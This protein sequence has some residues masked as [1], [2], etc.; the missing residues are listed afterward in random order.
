M[1][2]PILINSYSRSGSVFFAELINSIHTP[3]YVSASVLH[4]PEIIGISEAITVT[5]IR[6]PKECITSN[7]FLGLPFN[8]FLEDFKKLD[9]TI[10]YECNHYLKFLKMSKL[11][12][13][14]LVDFK[15]LI[16]NPKNEIVKFLEKNNINKDVVI[17][18]DNILKGIE[19]KKFPDD[20]HDLY[21]GHFP[22]GAH[23]DPEYLKIWDHINN[24]N[25]LNEAYA[26]YQE[27]IKDI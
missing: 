1:I 18:V 10:K 25:M 8:N 15:K 16:L 12:E 22:R 14:Y 19:Q 27:I 17:D 26:M 3:E 23:Q 20:K 4:V 21:T 11:K 5:I 9:Y 6:D 7:I 13:S 2:K 24:S